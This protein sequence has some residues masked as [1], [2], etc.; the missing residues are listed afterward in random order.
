MWGGS[1][2]VD[3]LT[4][5]QTNKLAAENYDGCWILQNHPREELDIPLFLPDVSQSWFPT[6]RGIY[7]DL[8][9]VTESNFS[10]L[11]LFVFF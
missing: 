10:F 1:E 8:R 2:R 4:E 3:L 6:Y 9:H 11:C 7:S 5:E